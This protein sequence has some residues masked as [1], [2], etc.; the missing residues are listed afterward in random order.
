MIQHRL[1]WKIS[2]RRLMVHCE[3]IMIWRPNAGNSAIFWN[4]LNPKFLKFN[5]E[6]LKM[7]IWGKSREFSPVKLMT[8][9][10][11]IG[12]VILLIF[13]R[14]C[15]ICRRI[16]KLILIRKKLQPKMSTLTEATERVSRNLLKMR[17]LRCSNK[18][19]LLTLMRHHQVFRRKEKVY[20]LRRNS[21]RVQTEQS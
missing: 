10:K 17:R 16:Y 3:N 8:Q 11:Q 19:M 21:R 15:N 2:M 12:W 5:Q 1:S 14:C 6:L 7:R 18:M 20:A 4:H 13:T 9:I